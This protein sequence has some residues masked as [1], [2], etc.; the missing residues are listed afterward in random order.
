MWSLYINEALSSH[1][2]EESYVA[3]R[4]MNATGDH[5]IK[6]NISDS[7]N[8]VFFHLYTIFFTVI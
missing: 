1:N 5:H 2:K 7:D 3:C 4:K 8:Y 6:E